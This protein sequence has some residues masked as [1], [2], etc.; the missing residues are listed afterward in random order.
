MSNVLVVLLFAVLVAGILFSFQLFMRGD[1]AKERIARLMPSDFKPDL[2]SAR[3][4]PYMN[5]CSES[6]ITGS[7]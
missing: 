7:R 2:L 6:R 1:T 3:S 4:N 5:R